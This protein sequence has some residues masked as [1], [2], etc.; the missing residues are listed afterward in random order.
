MPIKT[1]EINVQMI[2]DC[3]D[4]WFAEACYLYA[5]DEPWWVFPSEILAAQEG[6]QQTDP[7]E[8]TLRGLMAH[9]RNVRDGSEPGTGVPLYRVIP[10]PDGWISS[11]EIMG[12]WLK[13]E[14]YHQGPASGG[15]FGKV[16]RRM[17]FEPKP[18]GKGRERGWVKSTQGDAHA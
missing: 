5:S 17:G 15:R 3:R 2:E 8:D 10:W 9:G 1:G 12:D 18:H 6:R 16:M 11:A 4:Q 7:W 13:L 14:P